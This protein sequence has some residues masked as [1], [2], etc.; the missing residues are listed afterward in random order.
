M[1]QIKIDTNNIYKIDVIKKPV[2]KC[3]IAYINKPII[4]PNKHTTHNYL[5][6]DSLE[7]F[8]DIDLQT[9]N[10]CCFILN[11]INMK[12]I[13]IDSIESDDEKN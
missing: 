6:N 5:P 9:N 8:E 10:P 11:C 3:K 7:F 4:K 1:I 2:I 13:I 12:N